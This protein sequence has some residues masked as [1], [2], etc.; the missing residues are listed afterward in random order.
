MDRVC[1][2]VTFKGFGVGGPSNDVSDLNL[3]YKLL[4]FAV[5]FPQTLIPINIYLLVSISIQW[6]PQYKIC[7]LK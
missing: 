6:S 2:Y 7:N 4:T 3:I 1:T 5:N